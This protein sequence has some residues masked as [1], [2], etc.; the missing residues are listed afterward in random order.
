MATHRINRSTRVGEAFKT[1]A[2]GTYAL[3]AVSGR[4]A[5]CVRRVQCYNAATITSMKDPSENDD[6]PGAVPAG[7]IFDADV[8]AI[9]FTG[10][11]IFVEW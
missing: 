3:D 2:A 11:P 4:P 7:T 8:S 5:A 1:L 10:G 6:A 9:T